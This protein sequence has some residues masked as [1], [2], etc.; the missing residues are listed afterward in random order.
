MGPG[1]ATT[2]ANNLPRLPVFQLNQGLAATMGRKSTAPATALV[3]A[4]AAGE[5][6]AGKAASDV[7]IPWNQS[8]LTAVSVPTAL[9]DDGESLGSVFDVPDDISFSGGDDMG[10]VENEGV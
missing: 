8:T 7:T 4:A 6:E 9:A 3:A 5:A 1:S 2:R 10:G